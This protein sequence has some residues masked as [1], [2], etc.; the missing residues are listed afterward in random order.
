[1]PDE[2]QNQIENNNIIN[3]NNG[4]NHNEE[5][6]D[7]QNEEEYE[8]KVLIFK[9]T[10]YKKFILNYLIKKLKNLKYEDIEIIYDK[11]NTECCICLNKFKQHEDCIYLEKCNHNFH[12]D[13]LLKCIES[14]HFLCP[15]CRNNYTI[16]Y[17]IGALNIIENIM[18]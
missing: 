16:D 14:S 9:L 17:F 18:I 8:L 7:I 11:F 5:N 12:K 10:F 4:I 3:I 1:M 2:Q 15:L 6:M 13:C